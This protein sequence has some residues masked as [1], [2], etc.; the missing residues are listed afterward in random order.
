MKR[1]V[2]GLMLLAAAALFIAA[3]LVLMLHGRN[4]EP[5]QRKD[6]AAASADVQTKPPQPTPFSVEGDG[7]A[8]LHFARRS[9][10]QIALTWSEPDGQELEHVT[11]LR[12]AASG[13]DWE[14]RA[15]L[16]PGVCAY[17]DTLEST[18]PQ[19]YLYRVDVLPAHSEAAI[20]GDAIPASNVS[21]CLD[22]GHYLGSSALS[23]TELYG[24][25]EGLFTLRLG[26]E[27][28][29]VL[30]RDYGIAVTMTRETD[31][32][33]LDGYTNAELDNHHLSLRGM[34]A[35]GQD[36]FVS[37][38]TN[39]NQ[40]NVNGAPTCN[41]PVAI[42]KTIV[43]VNQVALDS[44]R[45]IR[46]ANAVLT[47]LSAENYALGLSVT[48]RCDL[49]EVGAA[50]D[51]SDAFND[52]VDT[53]GA[54]CYRGGEEQKDYYGVLR[55]AA[56]VGVPGL[57]V[58]H[59]FHTVAEVRKAAMQGDLAVRWAQADAAGIAEGFGFTRVHN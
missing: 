55:G 51:W 49:A 48:D 54:V 31:D 34:Y 52:S 59:G 24:Y 23:G 33:T 11:V 4:A 13:G 5:P 29:A 21:V 42:N 39:A 25:G 6:P 17:A 53:P 41:Q 38:H 3:A 14:R 40:D 12:R 43:F 1:K 47:R 15:E 8:D 28:R 26:L 35:A 57:I 18:E 46:I 10:S 50:H 30:E 2:I 16:D 20:R 37:L 9:A 44:E 7:V 22:P 32:I 27:L 45:G 58:E 19:Q 36:L 56:S